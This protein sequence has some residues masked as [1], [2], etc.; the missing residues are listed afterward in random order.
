MKIG[1]FTQ[2]ERVYLP[3]PV[4]HV[5]SA[6]PERIAYVALCSPMSTH[7][8]CWKGLRKHFPV[9][10]VRGA[11]IMASRIAM[12]RLGPK[13][14][15]RAPGRRFWTIA[16]A[17]KENGIPVLH[18]GNVNSKDSQ[19]IL[20]SHPADLLVSVSCPQIL[21][22]KVL[23]KFRR[24]AINVHS[25]PLP[26][27]RGLMP[28]FW[29]LYHGERETAVTVHILDSKI[30]N[31]DILLQR[32]VSVAADD[33]WDSLVRRTKIT[34][35]EA[36]VD[37]IHKVEDGTISRRKNDDEQATCLSFPTAQDAAE[38]RRRGKRMFR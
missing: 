10:G 2:D 18:L 13:M 22:K 38:F 21:R 5:M 27:Y 23:A 20:D 11:M 9:F 35:G 25:S 7:G 28:A 12:A 26:K 17:A 37:A 19:E 14:G 16:D 33:T 8:G 30:D 3:I 4:G 29:V 36:L 34:G 24:G 31:G 15:L 32:P 1:I 6:M